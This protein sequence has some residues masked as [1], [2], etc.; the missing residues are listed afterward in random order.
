MCWCY[1]A[2]GVGKKKADV[3]ES[4]GAVVAF[5]CACSGGMLV[6]NKLAVHHVGAPAFVT[7]ASPPP[8]SCAAA[9]RAAA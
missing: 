7:L 2:A 4:V 3:M 5:Y 9:G 1:N 8:P 6:L